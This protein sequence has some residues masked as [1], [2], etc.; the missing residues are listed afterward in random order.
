MVRLYIFCAKKLWKHIVQGN[1]PGWPFYV[2]KPAEA[3]RSEQAPGGAA[4]TVLPNLCI[5]RG[6]EK[7]LPNCARE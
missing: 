1:R 3:G 4:K 7:G 5:G 2:G 6:A